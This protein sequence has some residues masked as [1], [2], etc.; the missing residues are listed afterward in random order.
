MVDLRTT[1]GHRGPVA[2]ASSVDF[3]MLKISQA[4]SPA[5]NDAYY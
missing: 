1:W 2:S 4:G 3:Y 5:R